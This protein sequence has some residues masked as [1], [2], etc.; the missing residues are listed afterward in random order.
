LKFLKLISHL[1]VLLFLFID[2]ANFVDLVSHS[3]VVHF[4]G[5][6]PDSSDTSINFHTQPHSHQYNL[7]NSS[8]NSRNQKGHDFIFDQDSPSVINDLEQEC[9]NI[10]LI[11]KSREISFENLTRAKPLY[12]ENCRLQI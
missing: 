8:K 10:F 3:T 11:S 1:L 4:E 6:S 5:D 12:I 9:V 2:A 7:I